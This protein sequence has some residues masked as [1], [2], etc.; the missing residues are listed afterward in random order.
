MKRKTNLFYTE[1]P[2][3]KFLTFSNYTESMT[4]N[5]LSVD[6]KIFP[7]R[8][9]CLAIDNL[10]NQ[11]KPKLIQYLAAYYENK[12]A[13]LR[14]NIEKHEKGLCPIA[15][16]LE[17]L[18]KILYFNEE[19]GH[20]ELRTY[21]ESDELMPNT[22]G[23]FNLNMYSADITEQ[24]Y[25][26]I[27]TDII[28]TIDLNEIKKVKVN[29]DEDISITTIDYDYEGIYGWDD[30]SNIPGY[31]NVTPIFDFNG[32]YEIDTNIKSLEFLKNN[33]QINK[34]E[35]NCIIPLYEVTNINYKTNYTILGY[36]DYDE[37][38]GSYFVNLNNINKYRHNVPLGIWFNGDDDTDSFITIIR[39]S[40]T[41]MSPV[42]SLLISTQFKPFPY[43]TKYE[44]DA[45][46]SEKGASF[47]T[48]SQV[49]IRLNQVMDKFEK[50]NNRISGLEA[51]IN[52]IETTLNNISS[53]KSL[54][55]L[56]AKMNTL[57][58]DLHNDMNTFK[59]EIKS[60]I[61]NIKWKYQ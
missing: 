56:Q 60:I 39:D 37:D 50:T 26:G 40:L 7:S 14:D 51:R 58:N 48:F 16:L 31:E 46:N 15:Y 49:L 8:F 34:L 10:T 55:R 1:G 45:I 28:C 19:T 11:T 21:E 22:E 53:V 33:E 12:M 20:N 9:L 61:D 32:G 47:G 52:E 38:T 24:D 6:T 2:D 25:N 57:D 54:D 42:W 13:F 3:S 23:E 41:G 18:N 59:E 29:F 4:G 43:S 36:D 5:F 27:Y 30:I 44:I 35:F 17:A